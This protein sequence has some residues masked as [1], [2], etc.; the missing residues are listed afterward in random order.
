MKMV[1][2]Y[3]SSVTLLLIIASIIA[4]KTIAASGDDNGESKIASSDSGIRIV[5]ARLVKSETKL[6]AHPSAP[7]ESGVGV[8]EYDV[9]EVISG[10]IGAKRIRVRYGLS[11]LKEPLPQDAILILSS[12]TSAHDTYEP[13][14][15]EAWRGI[16]PDT[17]ANRK[18][19]VESPLQTMARTP[20]GGDLPEA[21]ARRIAEQALKNNN[22]HTPHIKL[23][24]VKR[25]AF[26]WFIHAYVLDDRSGHTQI[27]EFSIRVSDE[28][29]VTSYMPSLFQAYPDASAWTNIP[30]QGGG[31]GR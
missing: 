28:G 12:Y 10:E 14:G 27:R 16:L 20:Q 5:V 8:A 6:P 24:P 15:G 11:T 9:K 30:E 2:R 29:E 31:R 17:Q 3:V 4:S 13:I 18:R 1:L 22:D 23:N 26:G 19:I 7:L 21:A 25:G